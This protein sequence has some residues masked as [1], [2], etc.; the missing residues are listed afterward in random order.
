MTR[1]GRP[2]KAE[3]WLTKDACIL[4]EGWAR[5]G[6]SD[7][8]IASNIGISTSTFYAWKS[9][10]KEFSESI[11]RGKEPVDYEV[12]N[13][14]LKSAR[15]YYV[16]VRK[17]IKVKTEKQQ[18]GKGKVVIEHIEYVDEQIY[19]KPDVTAQIFWLKNRKPNRWRDRPEVSDETALN[20]LD[21]ILQRMQ[22][23]A[24]QQETV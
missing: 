20:K 14:M 5:D 1:V 22:D 2:S 16:N 10:Y 4:L 17:P 23:D 19:I 3:K 12:E 7:E 8:Q 9:K 11:K 18:A 13:A 21:E 24:V 15:G 6:L